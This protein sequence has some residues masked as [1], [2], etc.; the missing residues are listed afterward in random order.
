MD[1]SRDLVARQTRQRMEQLVPKRKRLAVKCSGAEG[2]IGSSAE[3]DSGLRP[4][5]AV[6]PSTLTLRR[7]PLRGFFIPPNAATRRPSFQR[8]RA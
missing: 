3:A 7:T 1:A 5:P 6:R 2:G 8:S 4:E